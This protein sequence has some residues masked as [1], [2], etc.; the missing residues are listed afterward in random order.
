MPA[1]SGV[2]GDP[3]GGGTDL[4]HTDDGVLAA[5]VF[6]GHRVVRAVVGHNT[7]LVQAGFGHGDEDRVVLESPG[8]AAVAV[9]ESGDGDTSLF[10]GYNVGKSH[11]R[12]EQALVEVAR[13]VGGIHRGKGE[14]GKNK[15]GNKL[16]HIFS[17]IAGAPPWQA[18]IA[19]NFLAA[20]TSRGHVLVMFGAWRWLL[21]LV[22][23]VLITACSRTGRVEGRYGDAENPAILYVFGEDG[24]WRAEEVVEVASGVFPH[25]AGLRLLG[26]YERRGDILL[27]ECTQVSRQEPMTGEFREE[28]I[29]LPAYSHRLRVEDGALFPVAE[30][31]GQEAAFASDINPLGARKLIPRVD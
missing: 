11:P 20:F 15:E 4:L 16:S 17:V 29:G 21:L 30:E 1:G 7:E 28:S 3:V 13:Q 22:L 27:L 18:T 2:K 31:E 6:A 5:F 14:E 9:A 12:A 25:G 23:V 10:E 8:A 24:S 26:T 19:G